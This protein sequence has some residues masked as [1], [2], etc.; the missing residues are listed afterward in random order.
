MIITQ[1]NAFAIRKIIDIIKAI[2]KFKQTTDR[3]QHCLCVI[4]IHKSYR[5]YIISQTVAHT[6]MAMALFV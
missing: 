5:I 3:F 6:T 1:R 4:R 2:E